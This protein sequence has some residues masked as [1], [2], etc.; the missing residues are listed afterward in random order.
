M[1]II[2]ESVARLS[3]VSIASESMFMALKMESTA[4]T[5]ESVGSVLCASAPMGQ[6]NIEK[7]KSFPTPLQKRECLFIILNRFLFIA[8]LSERAPFRSNLIKLLTNYFKYA[9]QVVLV[10]ECYAYLAI[11]SVVT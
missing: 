2:E 11:A 1:I 10:L 8:Y 7:S 3:A 4:I 6:A 5:I 9:F